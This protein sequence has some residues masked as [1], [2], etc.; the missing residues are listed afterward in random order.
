MKNDNLIILLNLIKSQCYEYRD[1]PFKLSSG[2]YS[3]H[4]FDCRNL[5]SSPNGFNLVGKVMA[6]ILITKILNGKTYPDNLDNYFPRCELTPYETCYRVVNVQAIG[7]MAVGSIS[8]SNAI[9]ANLLYKHNIDINT[10]YVRKISKDH[11]KA[12]K[13]VG[14]IERNSKVVVIDDVLTSGQSIRDTI[15]AVREERQAVVVAVLVVIDRE[16]GGKDDIISKFNIPVISVFTKT[17]ILGV[18]DRN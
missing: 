5:L 12:E 17:D 1:S 18:K 6:E 2:H 15:E 9:M 3:N 11:G 13:V 7:G 8:V 16:E 4:Y 14:I 10:F